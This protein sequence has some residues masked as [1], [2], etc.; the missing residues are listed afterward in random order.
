VNI[1]TKGL[2]E[3][4]LSLMKDSVKDLWVEEDKEFLNQLSVDIAREKVLSET[5][6]NPL[7]HQQNL[8]HLA[9]TMQGEVVIKGLKLKKNME[10]AFIK[11]L[12]SI[13]KTVA[14]TALKS[15]I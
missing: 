14:I 5:G 8:L 6:P 3:Q 10:E 12:I 2:Q 4:V 7:E 11:I 1:D 15:V 9:A 13:I